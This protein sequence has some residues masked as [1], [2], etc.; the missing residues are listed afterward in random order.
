MTDAIIASRD[1]AVLTLRFNRPD[2]KNAITQAMYSTLADELEAAA[3]DDRVRVVVF[4]GQADCFTAGNDLKD[5][6]A[7]VQDFAN[8]PVL[9]FLR[10]A[11]VFPKPMLAGVNGHAVG[12]GTTLLLHCDLVCLGTEARLQLPFVSLGLVPEFASS[13]ILPRMVGYPKAAEWLLTGQPFGAEAALQAGMV[14][15]VAAPGDVDTVVADWAQSLAE[16]PPQA[17]QAARRLMRAPTQAETLQA[18]ENE[19]EV[20]AERLQSREFQQ[21]VAAFFKR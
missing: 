13:L 6:M 12:I 7:G 2:K 1:G 16:Q 3:T 10:T 20:F 9:R 4:A 19:A 5:F 15:R 17:L 11:A 18:I 8:S 21:R 14:N